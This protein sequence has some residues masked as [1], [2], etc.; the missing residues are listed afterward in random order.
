MVVLVYY[1][2]GTQLV[3]EVVLLLKQGMLGYKLV[4]MAEM[5]EMVL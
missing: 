3:V 1:N 2:Q 5:A 4:F